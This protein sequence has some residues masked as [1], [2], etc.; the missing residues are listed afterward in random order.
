MAH[1]YGG[2]SGYVGYSE[3]VRSYN[4]KREGRFPKTAFK[5]EYGLS[6]K[7]FNALLERGVIANSE[8]HHTSKFGNKTKFYSIA[9][10]LLFTY[11]VDGRDAAFQ[12]YHEE[13]AKRYASKKIINNKH[14][15]F[16]WEAAIKWVRNMAAH[17]REFHAGE[18]ITFK[19]KFS[20]QVT[21]TKRAKRLKWGNYY[22]DE[23]NTL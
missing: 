21:E 5:R 10:E 16:G 19:G 23:S 22:I 6:E 13:C 14:G 3:S 18:V 15:Q 2:N 8:W 1:Y 11:L 4:A 12:L 20:A 17:G 9:N 7:T